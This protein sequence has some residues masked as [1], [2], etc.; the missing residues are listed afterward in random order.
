M[1]LFIVKDGIKGV[2]CITDKNNNQ[3]LDTDYY[4]ISYDF[5]TNEGYI[6][7]KKD[8]VCKLYTQVGQ[9]INE[10]RYFKFSDFKGCIQK[11][12]ILKGNDEVTICRYSEIDED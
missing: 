5:K 10:T 6:E 1:R 3:V 12:K 8:G 2:A 11:L 7:K 4:A 9:K